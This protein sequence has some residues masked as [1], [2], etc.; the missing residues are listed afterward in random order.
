M[1]GFITRFAHAERKI[2]KMETVLTFINFFYK[3]YLKKTKVCIFNV[4]GII[5]EKALN[6]EKMGF[7][8]V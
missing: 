3:S 1:L 7:I 6:K 5:H 2:D 4:S 8:I